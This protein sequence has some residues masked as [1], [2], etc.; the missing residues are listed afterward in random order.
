MR[1]MDIP[2]IKNSLKFHGLYRP[3]CKMKAIVQTHAN[4]YATS[5]IL[6]LGEQKAAPNNKKLAGVTI[7]LSKN[8]S[9]S[10]CSTNS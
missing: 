10:N 6:A 9:C 3:C 4:T 1:L 7:G 2:I 8:Y 5:N